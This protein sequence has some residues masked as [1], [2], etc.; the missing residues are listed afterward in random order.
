MFDIL[1][2]ER[3]NSTAAK[4]VFRGPLVGLKYEPRRIVMDG[5]RS[6]G[7]AQCEVLPEVGHRTSRCL[8]NLTG[9]PDRP[10]RR[11]VRQMQRFRSPGPAQRFLSAHAVIYGQF[12][13]RR[14]L[15]TAKQYPCCAT[16]SSG[17]GGRR[18][19]PRSPR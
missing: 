2:H 13:S 14:H 15:M 19:L 5:L 10:M 6:H 7:V 16:R 4:R 12:R 1:V 9:N 17:S 18:R 3:G 11:R 8:D